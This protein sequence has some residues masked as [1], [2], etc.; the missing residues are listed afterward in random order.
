LDKYNSIKN[1]QDEEQQAFLKKNE[2]LKHTIKRLELDRQQK[3]LDIDYL[4][5]CRAYDD[6]VG[7]KVMVFYK[8]YITSSEDLTKYKEVEDRVNEQFKFMSEA[9]RRNMFYNA[10]STRSCT[11][12][13]ENISGN[14]MRVKVH[15][16]ERH[17]SYCINL[18]D[19][20]N[21]KEFWKTD[22]EEV[23]GLVSMED[24]E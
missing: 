15:S 10:M 6:L 20:K 18:D 2:N 17:W 4:K 9:H 21:V 14:V 1:K 16:G 22:E 23:E 3:Q 13:V 7:K 11:G 19:I 8:Q 5:Q 24:E 12:I